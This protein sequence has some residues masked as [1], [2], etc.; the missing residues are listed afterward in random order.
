MQV[1]EAKDLT[2][3]AKDTKA[4]AKDDY[5]K[6]T[7]GEKQVIRDAAVAKAVEIID[8]N[9]FEASNKGEEQ[10]VIFKTDSL[11]ADM[12][13]TAIEQLLANYASFDYTDASGSLMIS[14]RDNGPEGYSKDG[15]PRKNK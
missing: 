6:L 10:I 15:M 14:W 4:K 9:I 1:K 13:S 7:E 12:D 11:I 5:D 2:K 8:K 3:T